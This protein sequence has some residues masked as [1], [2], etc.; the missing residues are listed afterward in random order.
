M[1]DPATGLYEQLARSLDVAAFV[2]TLAQGLVTSRV[3]DPGSEAFYVVKNPEPARYMRLSGDDFLLFRNI[4]GER[5]VKD[6][7]LLFFKE[8][9]VFAF[10]RVVTLIN[11]L[12]RK[13]FL[14][15]ES[16]ALYDQV[17]RFAIRRGSPESCTFC[18]KRCSGASSPSRTSTRP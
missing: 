1:A 12:K 10:R 13:G 11:E 4:N 16:A 2:P 9:K 18:R 3:E 14:S 17:R 6:L 7:V 8:K 5:T 15:E